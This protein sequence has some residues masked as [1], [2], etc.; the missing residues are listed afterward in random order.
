[1]F[2]FDPF[3]SVWIY[4]HPCCFNNVST[5]FQLYPDW[6]KIWHRMT[7]CWGADVLWWPSSVI[8]DAENWKVARNKGTLSMLN[9]PQVRNCVL[10]SP[11][12]QS[13]FLRP[14][15]EPWQPWGGLLWCFCLYPGLAAMWSFPG[16]PTALFGLH[17]SSLEPWSCPI[18]MV[19]PSTASKRCQEETL[20][21]VPTNSVGLLKTYGDP[22][23]SYGTWRN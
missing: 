1:M 11:F 19:R 8:W 16:K 5:M 22:S 17:T 14:F 10:S 7:S 21:M 20:K 2:Q 9:H 15:L 12:F 18:C 13:I 4:W 6:K 23:K 3:G